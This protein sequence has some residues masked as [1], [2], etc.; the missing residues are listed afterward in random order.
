MRDAFDAALP[1]E[2]ELRQLERDTFLDK[3]FQAEW[4]TGRVPEDVR[5]AWNWM[6]RTVS[7]T[8]RCCWRDG[9]PDGVTEMNAPPFGMGSPF[10]SSRWT[11]NCNGRARGHTIVGSR[12]HGARTWWALRYP[13]TLG[14]RRG[15]FEI[16]VRT[17]Q[18][19]WE[20]WSRRF[21]GTPSYHHSH[22][23]PSGEPRRARRW[24]FAHGSAAPDYGS[25]DD[26][27]DGHLHDRVR[28]VGLAPDLFLIWEV[29]ER[30]PN[31]F[32]VT[33]LGA[34]ERL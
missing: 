17:R 27:G 21:Q 8:R 6:S 7:S 2:L 26:Q 28:V 13:L 16:D 20:S 22:C 14:H 34:I 10:R 4:E 31:K 33:E 32:V 15:G 19:Y 23:S 12:F 1:G 5:S 9:L 11:P 29:F 3:G 30:Y 24:S 25:F 18:G